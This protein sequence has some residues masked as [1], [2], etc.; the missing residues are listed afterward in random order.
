MDKPLPPDSPA[1]HYELLVQ[2]Q[3]PSCGW[4]AALRP[5]AGGPTVEFDTPLALAR[6]VAQFLEPTATTRGLR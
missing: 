6:Y 4:H 5:L 3:T 2:P 1:L